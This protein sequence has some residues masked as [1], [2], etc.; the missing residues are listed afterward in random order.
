LMDENWEFFCID[1]RSCNHSFISYIFQFF[2]WEFIVSFGE[3][4]VT[5]MD[6]MKK[7]RFQVNTCVRANSSF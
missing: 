3:E 7:L 4:A 1:I 2:G 5:K 6:F